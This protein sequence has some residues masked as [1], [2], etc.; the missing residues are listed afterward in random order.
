VRRFQILLCACLLTVTTDCTRRLPGSGAKS[1]ASVGAIQSNNLGVAEMN[2][3]HPAQALELFRRAGQSDPTLF[4]AR[5]NEGIALLNTQRND[6]AREVLRDATRRQPESARA[7]YNLGILY[8]NL[9]QVD[10]AIDAFEKVTRLDPDDADAFYFLGQLHA[11]ASRYDQAIRSYQ[12]CL[13][14]DAQHL[15]AEFGLARAYQFSGNEEAARQHL[16][17]FD[18][19]TQSGK[20]KPISLVY[21]EQGPY[22][23]AEPVAGAGLA[24]EAFSVR[25]VAAADR[26]GIRVDARSFPAPTTIA[27]LLA[28]GACFLDYDG[29]GHYDLFLPQGTG[30]VSLYRNSGRGAF[31]DVTASSGLAHSEGLGCAVGDYDNDGRDDLV[32]GFPGAVNV[33]R[34]EGAGSFRDVTQQTGIR[35]DGLP[36]GIVFVDYDHDGDV[37]L[38]ISRFENFPVGPQGEFNFPPDRQRAGANQLWRN[39]GNGTFTDGTASAGLAG[40]SP[41]IAAL[42]TDFNNDRAIDFLLTGM[43]PSASMFTNSREG[44]FRPADVWKSPFPSSA[45]GAIAFDFNK[46]GWMDIAL[47]HWSQPGLSVWKNLAGSGFE[48]VNIPDLQWSRGWGLAAVDVDNDGW[49]DVAVAGERNGSGELALLRNLGDGRFSNLTHTAGL[50]SLQL[51]RP[52]ALIA[53]DIDADGDNDL[54]LTQNGGPPVLLRNEGGN[55]RRSIRLALQGLSDNRSGIGTKVEVFAGAL[56]QKWEMPSA[57]GYLGQSAP[58]ILAGI[59]DAPEADIVRLLWP[60][61]VPQDEVQ[62]AAGSRHVLKEIDRRGSSC[63]VVFVWDGTKYRFISDIIGPGIVGEWIGPGERNVPDPTEYLKIDGSLVKPKNGRLSFRFAEVMEEITY[64]D[65]I[66]LLAIDHPSDVV[67][68]PNEYF[69]TTLPLPEFKVVASHNARP[70]RAAID[71]KGRNVLPLLLNRDRQYVTGFE[72]MQYPG[73]AKMHYLELDLGP[74]D[75]KEPLRLIMHGFID[76]FTVT[77]I[78]AAYQGGV[79]AVSPFLEVPDGNGQWK[80]VSD[81]IG[82]PAGLARTMVSDWTGRLPAGTSRVRIGT[83]L[84]IYWDQILIDT[85]PQTTP[86]DVRDVPLAEASFAFRGY[87]RKVEGTVPGDV[88]YIHEDVSPSGPYAHASGYHTAYGN[89]LPLVTE[90][91][92]RFVI[93][94]SGEEVSLEFDPST[95]PAVKPGWSRDYFLYADGFAKDMDFYSAYSSTVEPLPHHGMGPYTYGMPMSYPLDAAHLEYRVKWNTRSS[96][97]S[98]SYRQKFP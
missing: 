80:R 8:R 37:D 61:G 60:T 6:E 3:G 88:S 22:S 49:L 46:D 24:P 95:L 34:N 30:A 75:S 58:E 53:A 40:N 17:R 32:V 11:Q 56:R 1:G 59:G 90:R 65:H 63:P 52:R 91:D 4:T 26:S 2:R 10:D 7:W 68:T 9:A 33:Y 20:G 70:P 78:F 84:K 14:L 43:G 86:V 23:T 74:V 76:Y 94:G 31:T 47:T 73:F 72:S 39:N 50:D 27:P 92:D 81:D 5:L 35:V 19:L 89:V 98:T 71:D 54:L 83:N 28:G 44:P 77:S 13:E 18:Q 62:L 48:R 55:R 57:S 79:Q 51:V 66:R 38:Y 97:S 85:T 45:A 93:I 16:S 15:S 29:D 21:G 41:G 69:A 42:P 96:S 82:F 25:F 64:L 87:P 12:R 67:V 36:L